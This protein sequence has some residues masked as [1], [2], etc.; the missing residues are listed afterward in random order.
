[1]HNHVVWVDLGV[2]DL[3]RAVEFYTAVL[4]RNLSIEEFDGFRF[5]VFHHEQDE[6]GGCLVPKQ[7]FSP[8]PASSLIYLNVEGRLAEA[9]KLVEAHGGSLIQAP[10]SMG[11][12]GHRAIFTDSE[13]NHMALYSST[14]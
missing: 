9:A 10:H 11:P 7:D 2:A 14:N 12:H 6:V 8:I 1:M 5:A 4:K 13:G 3:D